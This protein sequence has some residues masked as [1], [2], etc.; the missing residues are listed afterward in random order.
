MTGT[1]PSPAADQYLALPGAQIVAT[2]ALLAARDNL[3]DTITSRAMMCV[4]G[5]TGL[6]KTLAVNASLRE[7]EDTGEEVRRITFRSRPTARAVRHELFTALDLPGEP[8]RHPS[9]FDHLLK[10]ALARSHAPSSWMRPSG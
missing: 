8:P 7:L 4:H 10:T 1:L 2:R 9:E 3:T 6:G 5:G